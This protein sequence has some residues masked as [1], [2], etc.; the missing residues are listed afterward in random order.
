[1]ALAVLFEAVFALSSRVAQDF[2]IWRSQ[3]RSLVVLRCSGFRRK[4]SMC[5]VILPIDMHVLLIKYDVFMHFDEIENN[6]LNKNI[7]LYRKHVKTR[8]K[9]QFSSDCKTILC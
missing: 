2:T 4:L 9:K 3:R 6:L 7:E 8:V 1:M 5:S